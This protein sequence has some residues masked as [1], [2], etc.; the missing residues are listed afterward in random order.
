VSTYAVEHVAHHDELDEYE[1]LC[2]KMADDPDA[3]TTQRCQALMRKYAH[4]GVHI[5]WKDRGP[6]H[7]AAGPEFFAA[8]GINHAL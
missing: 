1:T 5:G 2:A 3:P 4:A 7:L 8:V 6:T